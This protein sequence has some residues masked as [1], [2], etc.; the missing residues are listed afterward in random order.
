MIQVWAKLLFKFEG[1]TDMI[2]GEFVEDLSNLLQEVT[3]SGKTQIFYDVDAKLATLTLKFEYHS[4]FQGCA[5]VHESLPGKCPTIN[6]Q[7]PCDPRHRQGRV[8]QSRGLHQQC[9]P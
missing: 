8:A 7:T 1:C 2:N 4:E 6:D 5:N 9:S 3:T